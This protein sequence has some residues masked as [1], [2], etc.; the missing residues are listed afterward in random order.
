M[1]TETMVVDMLWRAMTKR[2]YRI[3]VV[4]PYENQIRLIFMRINEILRTSPLVNNEVESNTKNPFIIKFKNQSA[5]VGFT[6]GND[7]ASVRGQKADWL[8]LD[9]VDYMNDV[10]YDAVTTIAAERADIG[11]TM[12]S[13]PTGKR[14][15]FYKACTDPNMGFVEHFHPSMHN[16]GWCDRMEAE[17]RAQLTEQAYVHEIEAEFG[18]QDKGVF[19]KDKLDESISFDYYAYNQLSYEQQKEVDRSTRKPSMHIYNDVNPAPRHPLGFRTMGVDWDKFGASSSIII[20][21]YDV[22]Y[23]KFRVIKRVEMPRA[24]Y[25]YDNAVNTIVRL[26]KIYNPSFIYCDAGSGEYQIERLHILGEEDPSSGL[27]NKVKRWQF[28]QT[29]DVIDPITGE[30]NKEPMKPFM[31]NQLVLCF[32]RSRMI[33]SPFDT[34]LFTQLQDYEVE[35]RS[36]NGTPI[37]TSENEHFVDALGLAYLAMVLEFKEL[38]GT[39]KDLEVSSKIAYSSKSIGQAGINEMFRDIQNSYSSAG[40]QLK[41]SDD[42]RGD[43]QTWVKVPQSY[44]V[45]SYNRGSSWGSR[46][47]VRGGGLGRSTW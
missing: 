8:Y 32:E 35:R 28:S 25:S 21:D 2:N 40:V 3:V 18:T 24:E 1:K 17:F 42:L 41:P 10:C 20:L 22:N 45:G 4:T 13:T 16:P 9:E 27:K 31:V 37:Y 15:H 5:I 19:P 26:N 6:A 43:R 33:M 46:S 23:K 38:T 39:I 11:T 12:S 44:R 7:A 36:Q 47:S 34:T 29:I 30:T 14:S